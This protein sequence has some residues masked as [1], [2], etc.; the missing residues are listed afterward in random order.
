MLLITIPGT[1]ERVDAG[2]GASLARAVSAGCPTGGI[3]DAYRSYAEQ[4]AMFKSRYTVRWVTDGPYG[5][6]RWWNGV[7]YVR[8]SG[9]GMAAIPG[10]STHGT[11]LAIDF[12]YPQRT[13]LRAH[14]TAYGWFNTIRSEPWHWEYRA[15]RDTHKGDTM[16]EASIRDAVWARPVTRGGK[17]IQAIQELADAKSEGIR[18]NG[19]L[20]TLL[21]AVKGL[22][23]PT[24]DAGAV[25][26]ALAKNTTFLAALAK[27]VNDDHARRMGS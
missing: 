27:A 12:A 2:A 25:A 9:L 11:G 20:D 16:S 4:V 18:A 15:T 14:G 13:W 7:R 26:A 6:A 1:N 3:N 22:S 24:V 23:T 10:T 19:K 5:D 8:T 17:K 21:A